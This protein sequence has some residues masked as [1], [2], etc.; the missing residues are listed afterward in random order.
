M[1]GRRG[2]GQ[3]HRAD[4]GDAA[5]LAG[6]VDQAKGPVVAYLALPPAAFAPA[7]QALAVVGLPDGSRLVVEK[8]FGRSLGEARVLNR[9]LDRRFGK[10]AVFRADHVLGLQTVQNILGLRFANRVFEPLWNAGHVQRVEIAWEE[11]VALEGRAGYYDHAGALRDMVQYHLLQLLC[12][13]AMEPPTRLDPRHLHD[14]KVELLHAVQPPSPG[15]MATG[16]VRGRYTAGRVDGVDVPAYTEEPG[17]DPARGTETFAEVTLSVSNLRWAGVPFTLRTGKALARRRGEILV[18]FR[19]ASHPTFPEA[20]AAPTNL[21]RL[22]LDPDRLTLCDNLNG[23]G[24]PFRL[25]Q[26]E[27]ERPLTPQELPAY[28]RLLLAVLQGDP[29]CRSAATRPSSAGGSPNRSSPPGQRTPC[30]CRSTRPARPGRRQPGPNNPHS[31]ER[32]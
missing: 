18:H 3:L 19:A 7:I 23:T 28:G 29:T 15:E 2:A 25:E 31:K 32:R 13:V 21:L 10:D 6:A 17:V 9:L 27:L 5:A 1:G 22:G 11:T 24:D 14:R 4:S 26:A 30:R 20:S 8:P 12:L 16:T